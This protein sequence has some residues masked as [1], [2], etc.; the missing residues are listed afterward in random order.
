MPKTLTLRLDVDFSLVMLIS[1]PLF[2]P[3]DIMRKE[4]KF[5]VEKNPQEKERENKTI[6]RERR[7]KF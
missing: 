7:E 1:Y 2:T 4:K 6:S 3:K 5:K